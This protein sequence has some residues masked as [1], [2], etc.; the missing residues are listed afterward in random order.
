M[1]GYFAHLLWDV[2]RMDP[3]QRK[4]AL[5]QTVSYLCCYVKCL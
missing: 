5:Y 2:N 4:M 1:G 3:Q